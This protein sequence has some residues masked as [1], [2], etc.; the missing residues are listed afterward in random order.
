MWGLEIVSSTF[1]LNPLFNKEYGE[2]IIGFYNSTIWFSRTR[3]LQRTDNFSIVCATK[4][5]PLSKVDSAV[6]SLEIENSIVLQQKKQ[7][8]S[9]SGYFFLKR[10]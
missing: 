4:A 3:L 10:S 2:Y 8:P 5:F 1:Q 6:P 7:P 9:K